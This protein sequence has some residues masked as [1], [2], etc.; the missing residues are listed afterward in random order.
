MRYF[1][2]YEG[3]SPDGSFHDC[4]EVKDCEDLEVAKEEAQY[5][6][7]NGYVSKVEILCVEKVVKMKGK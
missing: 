7:T 2:W 1:I 5:L 4:R 3:G 6:I